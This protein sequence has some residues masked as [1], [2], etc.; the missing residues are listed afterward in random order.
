MLKENRFFILLL[1]CLMALSG[2]IGVGEVD[3]DD[4]RSIERAVRAEIRDSPAR[5]SGS[6]NVDVEDG[7]VT[8]SGT[9]N[10]ASGVG[11]AVLRAERIPGVERVITEIEFD[12]SEEPM[13]RQ[14]P[15]PEEPV[16]R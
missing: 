6:V 15:E 2:C 5:G 13:E 8:L 1:I 7:V 10:D 12:G 16:Q 11:D 9:V 4:D 14:G 3:P